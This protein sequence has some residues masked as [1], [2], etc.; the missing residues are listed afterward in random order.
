VFSLTVIAALAIP[1]LAQTDVRASQHAATRGDARAALA[2]AKD[3]RDWQPWAASTQL[4]VALAQKDLRQ[5]A[6]A[7]GSIAKAI[8]ADPSDWRL[9]V[10][11]AD[12]DNASG[13]SLAA[14]ANLRRAKSL[15]PRTP[16]LASVK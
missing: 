14:Q 10:V 4:Q 13:H 9:Y 5:F 12:I 11:A 8:K 7:R 16:L 6:A 2:R 1:L 3:A 15:S